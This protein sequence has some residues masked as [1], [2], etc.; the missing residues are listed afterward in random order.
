M[1][2]NIRKTKTAEKT[3]KYADEWKFSYYFVQILIMS[4]CTSLGKYIFLPNKFTKLVIN[5]ILVFFNSVPKMGLLNQRW[6]D[7]LS[8]TLYIIM[9]NINS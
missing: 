3:W 4:I 5:H 8:K 1:N 2:T 9:Y 7:F 6:L